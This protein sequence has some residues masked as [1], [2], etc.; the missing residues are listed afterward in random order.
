MLLPVVVRP[1]S[2]ASLSSMLVRA[3]ASGCHSDGPS[4]PSTT[5]PLRKAESYRWREIVFQEPPVS[6]NRGAY[7][8]HFITMVCY[9]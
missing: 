7:L 3:S 8:T 6:E 2:A 4:R 5:T 9:L 1:A